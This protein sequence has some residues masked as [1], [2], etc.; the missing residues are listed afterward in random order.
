MPVL[1][2]PA[3]F[4]IG[5][6]SRLQAILQQQMWADEYNSRIQWE[7]DHQKYNYEINASRGDFRMMEPEVPLFQTTDAMEIAREMDRLEPAGSFMLSY[8][9]VLTLA[10]GT[11]YQPETCGAGTTDAYFAMQERLLQPKFQG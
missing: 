5:H 6:I 11:G 2:I 4:E 9:Q 3:S 8:E 7:Y 10:G 1:Q